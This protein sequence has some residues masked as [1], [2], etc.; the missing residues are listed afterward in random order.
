MI[1]INIGNIYQIFFY[2]FYNFLIHNHINK[3][4]FSI[5]L[6]FLYRNIHH[7]CFMCFFAAE[8]QT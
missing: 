8:N 6:L 7:A 1:N 2:A 3:I 5:D 4:I